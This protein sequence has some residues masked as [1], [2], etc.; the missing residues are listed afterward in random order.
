MCISIATKNN[1][2]FRRKNLFFFL[3]LLNNN[4][5]IIEIT[6]K[7]LYTLI[8]YKCIGKSKAEKENRAINF[9]FLYLLG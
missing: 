3:D 8:I 9:L 5:F 6:F 4:N 7:Q 1:L 2:N